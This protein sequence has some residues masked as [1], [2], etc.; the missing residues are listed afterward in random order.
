MFLL[1]CSWQVTSM[2]MLTRFSWCVPMIQS[3]YLCRAISIQIASDGKV[4]RN[5]PVPRTQKENSKVKALFIQK[6]SNQSP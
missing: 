5:P 2:Y 3:E 6:V 4:T 1:L